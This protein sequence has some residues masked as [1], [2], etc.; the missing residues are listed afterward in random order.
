M[1]S[2]PEVYFQIIILILLTLVN[3]FFAASEMAIVSMDKKKLLALSEQGDK[4][5]I[6]V[7]KL[8]IEPSKFLSTIQVGITFAGFFTSASAAIG[9][10]DKFGSFLQSLS[11]PFANRVSL[12]LITIVLAFFSLVFG[13]LVP[14]RIA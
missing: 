11:I 14:K 7:E 5:A 9:L 8:L 2:G 6:K 1:D 13:E 3:A 12:V 4:R 10:S